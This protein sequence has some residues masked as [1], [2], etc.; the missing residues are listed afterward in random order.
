MK[1]YLYIRLTLLARSLI[2]VFLGF[3]LAFGDGIDRWPSAVFIG[4]GVMMIQWLLMSTQIEDLGREKRGFLQRMLTF[5]VYGPV[6]LNG[7][8]YIQSAEIDYAIVLCSLATGFLALA[9]GEFCHALIR[10]EEKGPGGADRYFVF[11]LSALLLPIL[12][13]LLIHDHMYVLTIG[14][15]V[16]PAFFASRMLTRPQ[17]GASAL[18]THV[19]TAAAF[20]AFLSLSWVF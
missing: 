14:F 2:P 1:H 7:T 18:W 4:L 12:L 8:Y 6:L 3:A 20:T 9:T 10:G 13:Y 15:F 16:F 5:T 19:L 17:I 11:L